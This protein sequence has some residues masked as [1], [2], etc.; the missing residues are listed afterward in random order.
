MVVTGIVMIMDTKA[1]PP[2]RITPPWVIVGVGIGAGIVFRP[3]IDLFARKEGVSVV[4]LTERLDFLSLNFAGYGDSSP[5]PED[6][7][8]QIVIREN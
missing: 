2:I 4:H 6:I 3:K 5:S 7:R 1:P 8:I